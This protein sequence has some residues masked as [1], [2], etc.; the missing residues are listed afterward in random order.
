MKDCS[1]WGGPTH[2]WTPAGLI[3][4]R[5][6][7]PTTSAALTPWIRPTAAIQHH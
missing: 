7:T 3:L 6:R 2:W 5:V 4:K 1:Y